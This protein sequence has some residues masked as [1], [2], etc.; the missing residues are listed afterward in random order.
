MLALI[1]TLE[2][3]IAG[4]RLPAPGPPS[5]ADDLWRHTCFEAFLT[6]RGL[7][8]YYEF[9][10][11]PSTEWA[12]YHFAAHREG[13]S[14]V[15][16]AERPAIATRAGVDRFELKATIHLNRLSPVLTGGSLRLA[17]TA[18]VEEADGRHSYWSLR[19]PPGR[20]DF[21]HPDGFALA[22]DGAE[23]ALNLARSPSF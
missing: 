23:P 15:E 1:Y 2:G 11:A 10:F 21:H 18:V 4:L 3:A 13:M 7:T 16:Q 22:L 19:H 6:G 5:R 14:V 20:P 9:N 17:L 12:L 8:G